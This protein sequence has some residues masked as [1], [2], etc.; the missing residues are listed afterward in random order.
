MDIGNH[1]QTEKKLIFIILPTYTKNWLDEGDGK[2]LMF[3][4]YLS[5]KALSHYKPMYSYNNAY[6]NRLPGLLLLSIMIMTII[7]S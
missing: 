5:W 1:S 7:T 2:A 6:S 3:V 4:M